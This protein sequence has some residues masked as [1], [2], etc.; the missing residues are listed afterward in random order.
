MAKSHQFTICRLRFF[1]MNCIDRTQ[2]RLGK[3][4]PIEFA[5]RYKNMIVQ[6]QQITRLALVQ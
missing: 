2:K 6:E 5:N 1:N 4:T 3:I